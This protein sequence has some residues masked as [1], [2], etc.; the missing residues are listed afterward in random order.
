MANQRA[1]LAIMIGRH[2]NT[3]TY[4]LVE[5]FLLSTVLFSYEHYLLPIILNINDIK[6]NCL[7]PVQCTCMMQLL[8]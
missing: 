1:F 4:Q 8:H 5:L 3:E 7:V 2:Y 6:F